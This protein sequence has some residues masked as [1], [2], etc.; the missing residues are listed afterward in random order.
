V[1]RVYEYR[2]YPTTQQGAALDEQLRLLRSLYNACLEERRTGWHRHGLSITKRAQDAQLKP[3]RDENP[4]YKAIH[5]HALQD[6]VLR[7]D[8]AFR[9]FFRRVKAG[10][11]PGY[12]RFKARGQYES[13][14][15]KDAHRRSGAALNGRHLHLH[16]VGEVKVKLHRAPEGTVKQVRVLRRQERWYA[17]LVCAA[18]PAKPLP[19][20][21][22]AL[23]LDMGI[24]TLVATSDGQLHANDRPHERA[25]ERLASARRVLAGR[26]KRSN[27]RRKAK[28]LFARTSAKVARQR[29]D[30]HHKLALRLVRENDVLCVEDLNI[31]GLA[32]MIL[33]RQVHDAGWGQFINILAYKAESAGRELVKVNP[34]G[35][36]QTCSVCEA[37]V[38]KDLSVRV[39]RCPCGYVADRDVNAARNVLRLGQSLREARRAA[40]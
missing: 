12:P 6:V 36:S 40:A 17:Q 29:L 8:R 7:C 27:R 9:A 16:G 22:K 30:G 33:S 21:G 19:T 5:F 23:G 25:R 10:Q 1:N 34:R 2:L 18:V 24:T 14:T 13:F 32:Q 28:L 20:T 39:H 37:V 15:Y 38:P 3:I 4:E 26:R 35:T 31:Q 11:T